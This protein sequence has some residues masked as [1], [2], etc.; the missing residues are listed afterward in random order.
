MK[1]ATCSIRFLLTTMAMQF[2]SARTNISGL[3]DSG[4]DDFDD[5]VRN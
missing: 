4:M 5:K 2:M 1:M 3:L